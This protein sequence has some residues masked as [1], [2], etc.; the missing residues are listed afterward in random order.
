MDQKTFDWGI[1]FGNIAILFFF[2][3]VLGWAVEASW[4]EDTRY[5]W[6][7]FAHQVDYDLDYFW[8]YEDGSKQKYKSGEELKG[9]A[10]ARVSSGKHRTNYSIGAVKAWVDGYCEYMSDLSRMPPNAQYFQVEVK[11]LT[12]GRDPASLTR[13]CPN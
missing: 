7:M 13:Q 3:I 8:I 4:R 2:T 5:A 6:T 9:K 1:I 12:N 10:A 11:Y